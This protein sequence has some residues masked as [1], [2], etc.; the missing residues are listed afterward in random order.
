TYGEFGI[1]VDRAGLVVAY[2]GLFT[3]VA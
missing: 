2:Q 1:T 3:R